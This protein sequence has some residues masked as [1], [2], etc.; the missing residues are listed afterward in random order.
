MT[1]NEVKNQGG[2]LTDEYI[3]EKIL[4]TLPD[5]YSD[6]ILVIEEMYDPKKYTLEQLFDT[7]MTF[8][9]RKFRKEDMKEENIETKFREMKIEDDPESDGSNELEANFTKKL[10]KGTIKYKVCF[11]LNASV[12]VI[13]V[14][15]LQDVRIELYIRRTRIIQIRIKRIGNTRSC[16]M[17]KKTPSSLMM[18]L[19]MRLIIVNAC[20]YP[21]KV[22]L[23]LLT[24]ENVQERRI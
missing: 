23:Y 24:L 19:K 13:L 10:K 1:G 17:L 14:I 11:P 21:W 12:V 4:I 22:N 5:C 3:I 18:N 9:M 16:I 7:L 20:F 6:K 15:M 2:K 8:E